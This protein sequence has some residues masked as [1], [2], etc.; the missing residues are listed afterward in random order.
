MR[1]NEHA[2]DRAIRIVLGIALLSLVFVGPK[3][4]FGWI[5]ILPVEV[6]QLALDGFRHG[7]RTREP[8]VVRRPDQDANLGAHRME[9]PLDQAHSVVS[10]CSAY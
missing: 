5:G 4:A 3:S 7:L 2:I 8:L 10:A 9:V 1:K 6:D